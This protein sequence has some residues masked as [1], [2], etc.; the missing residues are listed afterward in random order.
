MSYISAEANFTGKDYTIE[1]PNQCKMKLNVPLTFINDVNQELDKDHEISGVLYCDNNNNIVGLNKKKGDSDSVYTEN[2]VINLHTHPA[3][4]YN[5]GKTVWGWPSGEDMRESLKF[6]LA[7]NKAHLVFSVEGLYTIQISPCKIKKMK[8]L[9]NDTERGV[10]IFVIEEFFKST[11]NF[12]GIQEV[13]NLA[14]KG[15]I[16]NPYS[17]VDFANTFDLVNLL[18]AKN[19]VHKQTPTESTKNIGHTGIH[20]ENNINHYSFGNS[21][22]SRIPNI[23]FPD[24]T[25]SK[26]ENQSIKEYISHEDLKELRKINQKG[27]EESLRI[28]SVKELIDLLH[29]IFEKFDSRTC[30]IEWNNHKHAWFFVNFFPSNNYRNSSYHDGVKY[31]TPDRNIPV[32]TDIEPFIRIFSNKKEGCTVNQ[33]TQSNKFKIGKMTK[34]KMGGC[35]NCGFGHKQINLKQLK[36]DLRFCKK[37]C[38]GSTKFGMYRLI[39]NPDIRVPH[40]NLIQNFQVIPNVPNVPNIMHQFPP[41]FNNDANNNGGP[42]NIGQPIPLHGGRKKVKRKPTKRRHRF[43]SLT[44]EQESAILRRHRLARVY[45]QPYSQGIIQIERQM[46]LDGRRHRRQMQEQS[47]LH[48]RGMMRNEVN[49]IQRMARIGLRPLELQL[50]Q[51][52]Y[53]NRTPTLNLEFKRNNPLRR[54]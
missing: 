7:G 41:A 33:I 48:R 34:T 29:T 45:G 31:I 47:D 46:V 18:N 40:E 10:L 25:G 16:I 43:G 39:H 30:E 32:T 13:N 22:F 5:N 20:G 14:K 27:Q 35:T 26:I 23:G 11:H 28:K 51:E 12:R 21:T 53:D 52:A 24:V 54:P 17:Y 1:Q 38:T 50:Q 49:F 44:R 36:L 15:V 2:N 4:A 9:L 8:E 37:P 6:A 19:I 3:S 42:I